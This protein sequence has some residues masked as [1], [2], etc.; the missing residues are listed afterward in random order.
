MLVGDILLALDSTPIESPEE[1][2]DLL[3][4]TG[5]GH[6]GRL[7]IL[8]GGEPMDLAVTIGERPRR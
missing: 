7:E 2:M 5:A 4:T 1:L 6:S 8:R 3:F